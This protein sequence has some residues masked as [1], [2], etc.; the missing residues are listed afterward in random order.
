MLTIKR[1]NSDNQDFVELVRQLDADLA[2]KNGEQNSFYAQYNK[3]DLI[4]HVLV[5]YEDGHAVACGAIKEFEPGVMEVKRMFT[6]PSQRGKG[7]ASRV[8][9]EL[10]RW[11]AE[12]GY[13]K[14]IL[15]TG[16]QMSDAVHLYQKNGYVVI[17]N[18]G[19]YAGVENSICFEKNIT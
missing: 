16:R 14:C 10:E 2:R 19:Q 11:T 6:L 4:Q 12:L 5:A 13:R 9:A 15:E 8:L 1:T 7:V 17:K 18:Y 3:I